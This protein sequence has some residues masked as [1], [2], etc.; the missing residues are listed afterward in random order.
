MNGVERADAFER[1]LGRVLGAG[2]RVSSVLLGAGLVLYLVGRTP[3]LADVCL[4]GGLITLM[5]TPV[6]RVALS[7]VE[8]ARE[9]DWFFLATTT[10]VLL[11]LLATIA[12][13][14]AATW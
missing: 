14:V 13:A 12:A 10:A 8:Y 2:V 9:R 11:V 3:V 1:L 6:L 5:A 7:V 4:R